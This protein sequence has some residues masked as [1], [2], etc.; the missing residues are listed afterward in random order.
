MCV[1]SWPRK[2]L[3]KD[4]GMASCLPFLRREC[5]NLT[6]FKIFIHGNHYAGGCSGME[7]MGKRSA[8]T[9]SRQ[10]EMYSSS[11]YKQTDCLHQ[12]PVEDHL[13]WSVIPRGSCVPA[14]PVQEVLW[15]AAYRGS[16]YPFIISAWRRLEL[17]WEQFGFGGY[18]WFL[19]LWFWII[20]L[21]I[22]SCLSPS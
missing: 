11:I 18:I 6:F 10:V 1:L 22:L 9:R 12:T 5:A 19:F 14:V 17:L 4:S 8:P 2:V 21:P 3:C 20:I 13:G 16:T 15:W 7:G